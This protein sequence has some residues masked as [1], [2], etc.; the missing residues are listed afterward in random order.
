MFMNAGVSPKKKIISWNVTNDAVPPVGTQFLASHFVP[1]QFVDCKAKTQGKGTQ[2]VMKRWGF[3]GQKA[4]HGASLSHR[5]AGS[6]GANQDPGRVW[7]G[8]KMAGKMGNKERTTQNLQVIKVDNQLGLIYI[9]GAVPGPK[10]R[11]IR[12]TDAK[13]KSFFNQLHPEGFPPMVPTLRIPLADREVTAPKSTDD[14]FILR[15]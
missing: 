2:G 7:K 4:S 12:V 15:E 5:S 14:P 11:F 10:M 9:R 3:K 6:I 8:K 1:G 13:K